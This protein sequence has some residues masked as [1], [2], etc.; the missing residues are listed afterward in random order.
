MKTTA[1]HRRSSAR[2]AGRPR[3]RNGNGRGNGPA[4]VKPALA[5]SSR[6][7]AWLA[8]PK[9]NLING[10]WSPAASGKTFH[11]FNPA[12]ASVL[13][14]AADSDKEDINRAVTAAR[15]AFESGP[16]A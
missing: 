3:N 16:W 1:S 7:A 5:I 14:R 10:K 4:S 9:Q 13:A 2:T 11:V 12:D 15:R 8:K 6:V